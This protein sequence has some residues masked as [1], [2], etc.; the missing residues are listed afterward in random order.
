MKKLLMSLVCFTSLTVGAEDVRLD[1]HIVL[2]YIDLNEVAE[3]G[4]QEVPVIMD[5]MIDRLLTDNLNGSE[6]MMVYQHY[7]Y[8]DG[9]LKPAIK[10]H[11]EGFWSR[12]CLVSVSP[13]GIEAAAAN[14]DTT[15]AYVSNTYGK[16]GFKFTACEYLEL[17]L[18]I[19]ALSK[20]LHTCIDKSKIRDKVILIFELEF[21]LES[22]RLLLVVAG[23]Q[24]LP[25]VPD[26]SDAQYSLDEGELLEHTLE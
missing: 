4:I 18:D 15:I 26:G 16:T 12:A 11:C 3:V 8:Q 24:I 7:G 19:S 17:G 20:M 25:G 14:L 5:Q 22:K 21:D 9:V 6:N 23:Y 2:S 13:N 10:F 1:P